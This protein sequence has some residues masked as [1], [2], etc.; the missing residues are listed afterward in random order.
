MTGVS[1]DVDGMTHEVEVFLW[2]LFL[3]AH[4]YLA[5]LETLFDWQFVDTIRIY[6]QTL[7]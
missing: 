4:G 6:I 7:E 5:G 1:Q 2:T 3:F